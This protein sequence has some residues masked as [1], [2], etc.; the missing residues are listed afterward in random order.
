MTLVINQLLEKQS[1]VDDQPQETT[2]K[3]TT[4]EGNKT[5]EFFPFLMGL[6]FGF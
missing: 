2:T 4:E 1:T 6:V 5:R 3:E